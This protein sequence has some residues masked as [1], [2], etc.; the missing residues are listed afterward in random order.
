MDAVKIAQDAQKA[1]EASARPAQSASNYKDL[2]GPCETAGGHA[3]AFLVESPSKIVYVESRPRGGGRV[4][5]V[6]LTAV[7][8]LFPQLA[9]TASEPEPEPTPAPKAGKK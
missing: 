7:T 3:D 8:A 9:G 2:F 6:P 5:R 1:A 4:K